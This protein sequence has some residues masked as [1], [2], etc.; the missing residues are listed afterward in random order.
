MQPEE[1]I[2]QTGTPPAMPWKKNAALFLISQQFSIFGSSVAAFGILWYVTLETSSGNAMTGI[3]LAAFLP[4]VFTALLAGVWADRYNRKLLIMLPDLFIA[5]STLVLVILLW[6]G[7]TS[8]PLLVLVSALR[9]F[10]QGIQMPSVSALMPQLVP[11]DKLVR[12]NGIAST[13]TSVLQLAAPAAAGVLLGSLG[14]SF[15]LLTDVVTALLAVLTLLFLRVPPLQ[16]AD[17]PDGEKRG[18]FRDLADGFR[19]TRNHPFLLRLLGI[20]ALVY[21]LI[22]PAAFLTPLLIERSYGPEVWRLTFNEIFWT[23]GMLL[24][25]VFIAVKGRFSNKFR[26]M[27]WCTIAFGV[28]FGMLGVVSDFGFYLALLVAGGLFMPAYST[29][30]TVLVQEHVEEGMMGRVFSLVSIIASV[31]LPAG[32]VVFGPLGDV[33]SVETIMIVSGALLACVAPLILGCRLAKD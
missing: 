20:Y 12:I 13:L 15:T 24:G 14:I 5:L 27:F 26:V 7:V 30:S 32:M 3:I 11:G 17:R 33:F 21:F 25:G 6:Q 19:Y 29:A 28:S 16:R 9:S 1:T 23:G 4:Q 2:R 8:L 31:S 18:P 22:T 10:A